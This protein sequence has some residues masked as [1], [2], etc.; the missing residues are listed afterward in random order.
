MPARTVESPQVPFTTWYTGLSVRHLDTD[1]GKVQLSSVVGP[2]SHRLYHSITIENSIPAYNFSAGLRLQLSP[3]TL[4]TLGEDTLADPTSL[5]QRVETIYFPR[6][7]YDLSVQ[8]KGSFRGPR[9]VPECE[10]ETGH[11]RNYADLFPPRG[12]WCCTPRTAQ[13]TF[14][15]EAS[16]SLPK[17]PCNPSIDSE[18]FKWCTQYLLARLP[19]LLGFTVTATL[20]PIQEDPHARIPLAQPTPLSAPQLTLPQRLTLFLVREVEEC[21]RILPPVRRQ[22][23]ELR[24]GL[25]DDIEHTWSDIGRRVQR[26]PEWA[27][28]HTYHALGQLMRFRDERIEE[29]YL[30]TS[31]T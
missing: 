25:E 16:V 14:L 17:E 18:R 28:R 3:S 20:W 7:L 8:I 24:C 15:L 31:T 4:Q 1:I 9:L 2:T 30:G 11:K 13:D 12:L 19:P 26:S 22:I 23:V 21:L 10:G 6:F 27:R 29:S 5:W